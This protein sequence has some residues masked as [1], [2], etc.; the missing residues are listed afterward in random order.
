MSSAL[1]AL[2]VIGGVFAASGRVGA[3]F[4]R[5]ENLEDSRPQIW[6]D[7]LSG[8]DCYWPVGS[9]IGTFDEV[10]QIEESLENLIALKAG[11]AHNDFLETT[12]E[13]G[14]FGP[15]LVLA[16]VIFIAATWWQ[17]R[18]SHHRFIGHAA[19]LGLLCVFLQSAVDYPLRNQT[20]LCVAALLIAVLVAGRGSIE[21]RVIE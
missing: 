12:L 7:T 2:V 21:D 18:H 13:S 8:A 16:W 5:F 19:A 20:F 9:G 15:L 1:L 10:F 6:E 17:Q 14:I 3:T 4:D 11:R